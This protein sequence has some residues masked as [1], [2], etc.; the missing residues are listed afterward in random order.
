MIL[1]KHC[2]PF[3][4]LFLLSRGG[5]SQTGGT[6]PVP[7]RDDLP[8][9]I[10]ENPQIYPGTSLYGYMDGGADLYLEYGCVEARMDEITM[11]GRKYIVEQFR[12]DS[13]EDAFGIYSVSRYQCNSIPDFTT[14]GCQTRYQLQL[15]AGPFY[16]NIINRS[17]TAADSAFSLKIGKAVMK[18][19]TGQPA[20]FSSFMPGVSA[21]S[22]NRNALLVK[23]PLGIWN[24]A[25][26]LGG[27]FEEVSRAS[28]LILQQAG[29][30]VIAIKFGNS[31]DAEAFQARFSQ[32]KSGEMLKEKPFKETYTRL[33][34]TKILLEIENP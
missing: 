11:D 20:D 30:Q 22:I 25:P 34:D 10:F 32:R 24:G 23:G 13:P 2:L 27:Y 26:D 7:D 6:F 1:M 31:E 12:M 9:A 14:Y 28:A 33:S 4:I 18:K 3:L 21:D 17:G 16:I 5:W 19:I 8:G 15:A 29:H